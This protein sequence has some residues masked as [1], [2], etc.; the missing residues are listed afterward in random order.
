MKI[1]QAEQKSLEWHKARKGK[2][3][4]TGL[5][6]L[7]GSKTTKDSFT[8]ELLAERLSVGGIDDESAIDRGERL[9]EEGLK[10]FESLYGK[11]A[12]RVGLC[13]RE[14]N[15]F[16]ASSPDGLIENNG[17]Y[18]EAVEIK[19]LSSANHIRAWFENEIPKDYYPQVVQYFI[20]N[21]D[22]EKLYFVLYD[23]RISV[24]PIHV[25]EI[26][27]E[28]IEEDIKLF[29]EMEHEFTE[30]IDGMLSKIINI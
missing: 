24:K 20:V 19:C 16:I 29:G 8:Y 18:S 23:P 28:N 4:G 5:K 10:A 3:T 15:E 7:L 11:I 9:E 30:M 17:K 13:F 14:D 12:D 22:L 6:K 27:R 1:H 25:I 2:I 21:D 26:D